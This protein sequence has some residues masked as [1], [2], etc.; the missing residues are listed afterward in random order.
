MNPK[1]IA[2]IAAAVLVTATGVAVSVSTPAAPHC[3]K[4]PAGVDP[5]TCMGFIPNPFTHVPVLVDPGDENVMQP[6]D[7][8]GAGCVETA[9]VVPQ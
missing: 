6:G 8:V 1:T 7:S 3:A 2:G 4:R 9:C 5:T